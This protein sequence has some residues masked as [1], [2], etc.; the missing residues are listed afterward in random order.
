MKRFAF[1]VMNEFDHNICLHNVLEMRFV[2]NMDMK[3][4]ADSETVIVFFT[5]NVQ[6]AD[7]D[8]FWSSDTRLAALSSA[9][10][11]FDMYEETI[12]STYDN[13]GL[14]ENITFEGDSPAE[15]RASAFRLK[16]RDMHFYVC[17]LSQSSLQK[18][19]FVYRC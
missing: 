10:K 16:R 5:Q 8:D 18:K 2:A 6:M 19:V 1:F 15:K 7:V 4:V 14:T 11:G 3:N 17:C 12:L 9:S 13:A